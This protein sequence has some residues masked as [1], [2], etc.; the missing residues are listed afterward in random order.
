M[1]LYF[2]SYSTVPQVAQHTGANNLLETYLY[3]KNK[4]YQVWHKD[5]GLLGKDLFLDSGAFSA[6]TKGENINIDEYINFI[7]KNE[8]VIT[9]YAGLDVIGDSKATRK[10]VEYMESK[11]L[12]PLPTFHHG[13][14]YEELERM[15]KKYDY[16]AL[17]GLVPISM[18]I[19]VMKKHLDKCFR[20]I[21]KE[22]KVHGFGV[23]GYWAWLR[24]PFYSVDATSWLMGGMYRRV[25]FFDPASHKL[26]Q[27][28]KTKNNDHTL[29]MKAHTADYKELDIH[30]AQEYMKAAHFATRL[31][32]SRGIIHPE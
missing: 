17:G 22:V 3:F 1:K 11:G 14:D 8:K 4:D 30:N 27:S 25:I 15:V 24:Y 7:K 28:T 5:K 2:A 9:T 16:I 20:I 10:N 23:N 26:V 6:F 19:P 21:G 32:A 13:S 18:N 29:F 12:R 31:W